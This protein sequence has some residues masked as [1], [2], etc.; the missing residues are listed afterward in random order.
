M[1]TIV[2]AVVLAL[3]VIVAWVLVSAFSGF[4]MPRLPSGSPSPATDRESEAAA[5]ARLEALDGAEVAAPCRT[6]LLRPQGPPRGTIVI[7]HGFTNCPAQFA[8]VAEV[9]CGEGYFVLVARMPRHGNKDTLTHELKDLKAPELVEF[10]HACIDTAAG[11]PGP[12]AV[13]GISAGASLASWVAAVRPEVERLVAMA[14]LVEPKGLPMPV[15]RLLV[16]VRPI[17]PAMWIWWDPKRKADLGESP[18]VYPG[19]PLRGIVP[20]LHFTESLYDGH[21]VVSHRLKRAALTSNPSDAAIS[22]PAAREMM[23]RAFV[24]HAEEVVELRLNR[25]LK[26]GHDFVDQHGPAHGDPEQVA[27]IILAALGEGEDPTA[28]GAIQATKPI[29]KEERS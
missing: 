29:A 2:A 18:Y 28:G 4:G 27:A 26:W 19:F 13:A 8:E 7:W 11:L 21:T 24:G 23:Q 25:S 6:Q 10:A 5:F 17:V 20:F 12:L 22:L 16:R 14:P 15:G 3:V 1:Q 9:L